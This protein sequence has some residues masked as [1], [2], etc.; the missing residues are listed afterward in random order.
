MFV[1]DFIVLSVDVYALSWVQRKNSDEHNTVRRNGADS[2]CWIF[3]I[4][5]FYSAMHVV[6][7]AVLPP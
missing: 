1:L 7:S 2:N 4:I 3:N 6:Q 5:G